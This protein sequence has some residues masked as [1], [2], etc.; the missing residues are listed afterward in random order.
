MATNEED[1]DESVG[2]PQAAPIPASP[3][4]SF[5]LEEMRLR[6]VHALSIKRVGE[7]GQY[8]LDGVMERFVLP[9]ADGVEI[10]LAEE[11]ARR[12]G[13]RTIDVVLSCGE[14][15]GIFGADLT[16]ALMKTSPK[17]KGVIQRRFGKVPGPLGKEEY[18]VLAS[19]GTQLPLSNKR[20]ILAVPV[21]T[22]DNWAETLEQLT[23]FRGNKASTS[24]VG[25]ACLLKIGNLPDLPTGVQMEAVANFS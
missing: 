16:R 25:V 10:S 12:F 24:W 7:R 14:Y 23:F 15:S 6:I 18:R 20:V 17:G 13:E 2:L 3:P 9:D 21:I 1:V 11:L 8:M 22:R 4:E 19:D 5:W